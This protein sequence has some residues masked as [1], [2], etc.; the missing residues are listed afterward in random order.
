MKTMTQNA[1]GATELRTLSIDEV[2]AVSGGKKKDPKIVG[3][4]TERC[5]VTYDGR[6]KISTCT[7]VN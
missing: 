6:T 5:T 4:L 7:N 2:D 1:S 3:V